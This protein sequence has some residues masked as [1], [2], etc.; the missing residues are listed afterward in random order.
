MYINTVEYYIAVTPTSFLAFDNA[1][2]SENTGSAWHD[3]E[4]KRFTIETSSIKEQVLP[5]S[6]RT[7]SSFFLMNDGGEPKSG[8]EAK[9]MLRIL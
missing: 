8:P 3:P 4:A 2:S 5:L 6:L 9:E 7:V 1:S